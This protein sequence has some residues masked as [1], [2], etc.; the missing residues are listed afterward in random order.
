MNDFLTLFGE[1]NVSTVI[2]ISSAL[3]FMFNLYKKL[4]NS[5]IENHEKNKKRD[6]QIEQVLAAVEKYPMYRQQSIEI[7]Q[8]LQSGIDKLT[9]SVDKISK[10]QDQI[11][12]D[13]NERKVNELRNKL[14]KM[15][16]DYTNTEKNPMQA[17]T[18]LE[19]ESFDSMF[20][21]YEKLGGNG[22]MHSAVKPAMDRL[23][24]IPMHEDAEIIKLMHSRT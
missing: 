2:M 5:I 7:Q 12:A 3:F 16:H 21:D 20:K 11:E 17:W 6:E 19:K 15:Y 22:S 13:S 8:K 14:L 23:R 9:E 18:E 10:R 24:V 4:S 1:I